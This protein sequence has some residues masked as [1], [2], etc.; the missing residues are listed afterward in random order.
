MHK[1]WIFDWPCFGIINMFSWN[2]IHQVKNKG[3]ERNFFLLFLKFHF[4]KYLPSMYCR[5]NFESTLSQE[6]DNSSLT[7]PHHEN[8]Y[9]RTRWHYTDIRKRFTEVTNDFVLKFCRVKRVSPQRFSVGFHRKCIFSREY[10]SWDRR[11]ST[12]DPFRM[13]KVRRRLRPC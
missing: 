10:S 5:K 12:R 11:E 8:L 9:R 4:V 7:R 1:S 6:N 13:R 2:F 3:M